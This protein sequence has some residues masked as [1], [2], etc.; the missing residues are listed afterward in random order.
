MIVH[1][2]MCVI[3]PDIVVGVVAVAALKARPSA[4]EK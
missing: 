1:A 2:L 3:T 4:G